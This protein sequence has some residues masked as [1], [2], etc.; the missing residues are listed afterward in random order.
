[1]VQRSPEQRSETMEPATAEDRTGWFANRSLKVDILIIL[2]GIGSWIGVSSTYLQ[3]PIIV[4]AAPEGWALASYLA[5]IVQSGN[6]ALFTYVLYQKYS[7]KKANDGHLIYF[8]Y[9]IGCVAAI[10]MAFLYQ[11]THEFAGKE[12][13]VYL[14]FFAFLFSIVGCISSVLFMPYM[15]RFRDIYMVTYITGQNLNGFLSSIMTLIQGT[16]GPTVCVATN[17]TDGPSFLKYTPEPYF[18][19]RTFFLLVFGIIFISAVAFV[20]L[21]TLKSCRTEYVAGQIMNGNEYIYDKSEKAE[22][23]NEYIPENVRNLSAFDFNALMVCEAIICVL[24]NGILPGLMTYSCIP[25]GN[26][27]YLLANSL[28]SISIP[29]ASFVAYRVPH[30][31]I[32]AAKIMAVIISIVAAYLIWTA[33]LSPHPPFVG[34]SFGRL[35]I[36]N[37]YSLRNIYYRQHILIT[38]VFSLQISI[39]VS[40]NFFFSFLKLSVTKIVRYKGGKTLVWLGTIGQ[41]CS[42]FGA[43]LMFILI[44]FT[45]IF[46]SKDECDP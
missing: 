35:H 28:N 3:L 42:T 21:N 25:Y 38:L 6:V 41:I 19:P 46:V 24:G 1:M 40:F 34:T 14:M 26:N 20:L 33:L 17:S 12:H 13:S 29:L 23:N 16:G 31:S 37:T 27:T 2:F 43:A 30:T 32:K 5:L 44:N 39:W 7:P 4:R 9:V 36:V 22:I 45:H 15:G 8:V 10:G 18:L 11:V